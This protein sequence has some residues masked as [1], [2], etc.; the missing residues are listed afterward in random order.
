MQWAGHR[1]TA[2]L[3][4]A[5]LQLQLSIVNACVCLHH[6]RTPISG[7]SGAP[8]AKMYVT[9]VGVLLHTCR[10]RYR[11]PAHNRCLKLHLTDG[12]DRL[13]SDT[14]HCD[15]VTAVQHGQ[16]MP[17][18]TAVQSQHLLGVLLHTCRCRYLEPAYASNHSPAVPPRRKLHAA[19][20]AADAC[21]CRP[22]AHMLPP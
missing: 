14:K 18:S 13:L 7:C 20:V 4:S 3:L 2:G 12:E 1:A 21:S 17:A 19:T 8:A 16:H 6:S 11:E 9:I 22:L 10:C 5:H 15:A